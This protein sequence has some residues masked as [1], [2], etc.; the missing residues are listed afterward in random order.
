MILTPTARSRYQEAHRLNFQ[1]EYPSAYRDGHYSPPS[2]YPDTAT[3]N[4]LQSFIVDIIRWHGYKA[5]RINV[6]TRVADKITTE[7]SGAQ[8]KDKRYIKSS[9][10]GKADVAA[11]IRGRACQFE[12]KIGRDRP[13]EYQLR[14]QERER[15]A[16]GLYEFI[17]TPE[18]FLDIFDGLMYG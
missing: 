17:K 7:A 2:K 16:G 8:F 5:E 11:T 15:K 3:A 13:S 9:K 10:R 18:Q 14:E 1:R 12:I 4:G 6:V